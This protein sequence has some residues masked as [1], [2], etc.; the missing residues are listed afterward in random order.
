M[1]SNKTTINTVVHFVAITGLL[2]GTWSCTGTNNNTE[3]KQGDTTRTDNVS[4]RDNTI[5]IPPTANGQS[6]ATNDGVTTNN[7]SAGNTTTS[8]SA[9][10]DTAFI[11]KAAEIN[12]EEIK[13]GKLAQ[14]K[15]TTSHVKELGKMMATEHEQ[16]M[17]GLTALAK[18]KMVSLPA[19]ETEKITTAYKMLSAKT[20]KNFD[21][22]YSDMMVNGHKEAIA[23]FEKTA[24]ETKDSEVKQMTTTMIPKLKTHLEHSEMCQKECAKM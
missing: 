17:A 4:N 22:A 19:A 3:V 20:G 9:S 7:S 23:L 2:I 21:K 1:N 11:M 18:K 12:M 8:G 16:A 6:N 24:A 5:S 14:Q 10:V 13:L 15:G